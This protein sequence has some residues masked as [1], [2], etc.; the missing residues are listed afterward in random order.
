MNAGFSFLTSDQLVYNGEEFIKGLILNEKG[1]S[2]STLNTVLMPMRNK[3]TGCL[4][5]P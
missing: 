4:R 2:H 5:Y 3:I 1:Q